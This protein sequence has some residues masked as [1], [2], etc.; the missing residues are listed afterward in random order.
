MKINIKKVTLSLL[1][2]SLVFAGTVGISRAIFKDYENNTNTISLGS[3]N[4][5]VGAED[6]ANLNLD[7]TNMIPGEN[8]VYEVDVKN[9]GPLPG[10]FWFEPSIANDSEGDNFEPETE[11]DD[12]NGGELDTCVRVKLSFF[13]AEQPTEVKVIDR[14]LINILDPTYEM[15]QDT[16]VDQIVNRGEGTMHIELDTDNCQASAM[17]D[18][19]D[20]NLLFHLDQ[21]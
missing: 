7:F 17:G 20:F 21:V 6:P 14:A 19:L 5:Q 12:S 11:T 1:T 16:L 4:L 2:I 18:Q 9:T 8:R 15:E 10:N 3:L 13:D